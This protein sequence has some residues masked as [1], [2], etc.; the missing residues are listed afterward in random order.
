MNPKSLP[1]LVILLLGAV[2]AV[3]KVNAQEDIEIPIHSAAYYGN[4]VVLEQHIKAG[5]DVNLELINSGNITPLFYATE[6]GHLK[7]VELLLNNGA[8]IDHKDSHNRTPLFNAI[9]YKRLDIVNLLIDKGADLN[10]S[11]NYGYTPLLHAVG[12]SSTQS[13]TPI[14]ET[15]IINGADLNAQLEN[16]NTPLI[17]ATYYNNKTVVNMLLENDA[18]ANIKNN[19][20]ET[21]LSIAVKN[22]FKEI[23]KLLVTNGAN[24]EETNLYDL[25]RGETLLIFYSE[26]SPN[27]HHAARLLISL[28]ADVNAK[29]DLGRTPLFFAAAYNRMNLAKLLILNGADVNAK[30]S[31]IPLHVAAYRGHLNIVNLLIEEGAEIN[32]KDT[33]GFSPL[34]KAAASKN[35]ELVKYLI[36]KGA[37][38]NYSSNINSSAIHQAAMRG[39]AEIVQI[40]IDNGVGVDRIISKITPIML[41][42]DPDTIKIL[43]DNGA[44]VN[45]KREGDRDAF[46]SLHYNAKRGSPESIKALIE[47]GA[48]LNTKNDD[49][50]TPLDIVIYEKNRN[51]TFNSPA[52]NEKWNDIIRV[53]KSAGATSNATNSI[54]VAVHVRDIDSVKLHLANNINPNLQYTNGETLIFKAVKENYTEIVEVLLAAG[55]D[56]N[57]KSL[58]DATPLHYLS[59]YAFSP[60]EICKML[61]EAGADP[62]A[63]NKDGL[64]PINVIVAYNTYNWETDFFKLNAAIEYLISAG[65]NLNI[66][67]ASPPLHSIINT[68]FNYYGEDKLKY[69]LSIGADINLENDLGETPLQY[70]IKQNSPLVGFIKDY[71][72]LD[73]SAD[74]SDRSNPKLNIHVNAALSDNLKRKWNLEHSVD[75]KNWEYQGGIF[76]KPMVAGEKRSL[77]MTDGS[78]GEDSLVF[79]LKLV[80]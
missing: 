36:S 8:E 49:G 7:A 70:A 54:H 63:L 3:S 5:T 34:S 59:F 80:E 44:E 25:S 64:S 1:L 57:A 38:L 20:G 47:N 31:G 11:S 79:R 45:R 22:N 24:L 73:Y 17:L 72:S 52:Q 6:R 32:L 43:I 35:A 40:L 19:A 18:N 12:Q 37:N 66:K 2:Y 4:L 71:V 62:N 30:D 48:N 46:T 26:K 14:I 10:I 9:N 61:I 13:I 51:Q 68:S 55:A 16:G 69:L 56:A 77:Q 78:N 21:A 28:G 23:A 27:D 60:I 33:L 53:L 76:N 39:R 29:D 65:A 42:T 74:F 41:C 58:I 75:L 67:S 50:L 15:I